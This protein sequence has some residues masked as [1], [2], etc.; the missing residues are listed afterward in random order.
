[1]SVED[2]EGTSAPELNAQLVKQLLDFAEVAD[3][4]DFS[5]TDARGSGAGFVRDG[6]IGEH[7]SSSD[8]GGA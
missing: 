4:K 5:F 1:M 3:G 6:R 7:E 2:G 8:P